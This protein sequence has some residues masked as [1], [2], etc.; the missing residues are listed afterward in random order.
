[1][2]KQKINQAMMHVISGLHVGG[3]E[4]MLLRLLSSSQLPVERI[5]VVS[6][7]QHGELA[8]KIRQLG[9]EVIEL[10][11]SSFLN[12]LKQ[13]GQLIDQRQPYLIQ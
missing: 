13:L 3:A 2:S 12:T 9:V 1:M 6:L 5:I 10:P 7:T 8:S 4:M 11:R